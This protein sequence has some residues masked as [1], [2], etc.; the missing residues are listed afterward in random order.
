MTLQSRIC[1]F[2][3]SIFGSLLR[4][5]G[6]VYHADRF[7]IDAAADVGLR[8]VRGA[9][10]VYHA[11]RFVMDA[12]ADVYSG[13]GFGRGYRFFPFFFFLPFFKTERPRVGGACPGGSFLEKV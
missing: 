10:R 12:A 9:G 1:F 8:L 2:H 4:G 6:R 7:V 11:G 5:A 3:D 13:I